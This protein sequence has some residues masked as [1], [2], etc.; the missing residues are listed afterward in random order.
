MDI[1]HKKVIY[2]N[3]T[4]SAV[5][6]PQILIKYLLH[7]SH[8]SLGHFGA[9]KLYHFNKRLY[10]FQGMRKITQQYARLCH[11]CQIMNLQ[12][13][14]FIN[15]QKDIAQTPQD[16]ISINLL[17]PC[18]ITFQGNSYVLTTVC[19]LTG[20]LMTSPIKDKQTVTVVNHLFLDILQKFGFTEYYIL[21]MRQNLNVH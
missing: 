12:K 15:L 21:I 1:L 6:I 17:G 3:S 10:Y 13:Q 8:D 16:H 2:F 20:Y 14:H 11:K 19:N 7:A 4:F 5:V 18:N 9:M